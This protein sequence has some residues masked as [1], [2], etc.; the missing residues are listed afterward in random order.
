M[1]LVVRSAATSEMLKSGKL[2][3]IRI[4]TPSLRSSHVGK[5]RA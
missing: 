1:V 3:N 5:G 2:D 4:Y